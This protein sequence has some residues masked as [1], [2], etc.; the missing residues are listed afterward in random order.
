M[1]YRPPRSQA[2]LGLSRTQ[3]YENMS[4]G[5]ITRSI[6]VGARAAAHPASEIEAIKQARIAGLSDAEIRRLVERLHQGRAELAHKLR[7]EAGK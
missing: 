4:V 3:F 1:L 5:L 6:K 2:E 7:T